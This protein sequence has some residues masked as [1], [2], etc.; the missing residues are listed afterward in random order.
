[1]T[2]RR[3][4]RPGRAATLCTSCSADTLT[5]RLCECATLPLPKLAQ[6]GRPHEADWAS[7]QRWRKLA[8]T[9]NRQLSTLTRPEFEPAAVHACC[10]N[11]D[12]ALNGSAVD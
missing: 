12:A 7:W 3:T 10:A 9:A 8:R 11:Y 6:A 2:G 1:M 4:G 5:R